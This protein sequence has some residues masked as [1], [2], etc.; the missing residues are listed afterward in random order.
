MKNFIYSVYTKAVAAVLCIACLVFA[1]VA[2]SNG[3]SQYFEDC[4]I[5]DPLYRFEN[6]FSDSAYLGE[7]LCKPETAVCYGLRN[8]YYEELDTVDEVADSMKEQLERFVDDDRINYYVKWENIVLTNCDAADGEELRESE[9][10][11][12]AERTNDGE[13][14]REF[15]NGETYYTHELEGLNLLEDFDLDSDIVIYSSV[16]SDFA[17]TVEAIWLHQKYIVN[18]T[19]TAAFV[20]II[21]ALLLFIYLLCVCGTDKSGTKKTIWIDRIWA[22]IHLTLIPIFAVCGF[23]IDMYLVEINVYGR[24]SLMIALMLIGAITG[25]ACSVILTSLLSVVRN[26]KC[27]SFISSSVILRSLRWIFK[28]ISKFFFGKIGIIHTVMLFAY[29]AVIGLCGIFVPDTPFA[30]ILAVLL[31]GFAAFLVTFRTLDVSEIKKGAARVRNGELSY[32]IPAPKCDDL[33]ILAKNIN[34]IATGL[35]ASVAAKVKAEKMK[36][37]L[38]TN[39]SHDLKT[40]ITSIISYTELLEKTENLPEEARDYVKVISEKSNR[41]KNLT[42]DLF[43]ISKAQSGNE[44]VNLEKLDTALLINQSLGEHDS[45]IQ[46]SDI[47]FCVSVPKELYITADGRKMSRIIGNLISNILKYSMKKTR[48]FITVREK[49]E[50]IIMEFKNIASYP[51]DFNAEEITGRF[52][53]GDKSRTTDGNGLGLAIAKSYTELCGGRFDVVVDGDLFKAIITFKKAI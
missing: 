26:F 21:S 49:G 10:F 17:D 23:I 36:T 44:S 1:A 45:E 27:R 37:E 14:G 13:V 4:G 34:E 51:M 5:G 53:R 2:M 48:A 38:I 16:K 11:R 35:D 6:S 18:K 47:P 29:T 40:P 7:M 52:V 32:K 8:A 12:Y 28:N 41:L 31:F 50:N 15:K 20:P 9:F 22:E 39:V 33:K 42:L 46:K 19:F 30:L 43:D 3:A 24:L 25:I